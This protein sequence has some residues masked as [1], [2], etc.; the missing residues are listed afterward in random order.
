[1]IDQI[2]SMNHKSFQNLVCRQNNAETD[3]LT[4][5]SDDFDNFSNFDELINRADFL[6]HDL[7]EQQKS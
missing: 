1:M 7:L 4:D 5:D 2:I 6:F 3:I